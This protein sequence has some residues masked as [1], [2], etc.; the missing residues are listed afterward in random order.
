MVSTFHGIETAKRSLFAQMAGMNTTGHNIANASTAGYSRQVVG[1]VASRPLSMP[2]MQNSVAPGQLGTGVEVNYIKRVRDQF[3]DQQYWNANR[4]LG[5]WEVQAE[6]L[7]KLETIFNEPS[8]S[9]L[10]TVIDNFWKSWSEFS[11]DPE[12]VTSRKIVRENALA[13]ADAFNETSKKITD[14]QLDLTQGINVNAQHINTLTTQVAQLNYEI[15]R[16]EGFRDNANDLRDQRDLII[17]ELSRIAN[18]TVVDE[19]AGYRV[20]VGGL[21]LVAGNV[22]VPVNAAQLE[23]AY[24]ASTLNSGELFGVIKS[25]DSIVNDYLDQ[26]N[27]LANTIANGDVDISIPAG[28]VLPEGTVL[29]GVIYSGAT[30]T[31]TADTIVTV[32]GLNGLHKLGYLFTSPAQAAGE[33]FTSKDTGPITAASFSVDSSIVQD[34]N[35]IASSLRV[36]MNVS[37]DEVVKGNNTLALLMSQLRERSFT[38]NPIASNNGMQTGTLDDYYRAVMGQMGV[39]SREALRQQKNNQLLVDQVDSRRQ[40]VSA[41]SLDEEMS[42]LIKL[43][44]SYGA[45]SRL[46]TTLDQ[47]LDKIINSMGV[48][49]R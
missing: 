4:S 46:M 29:N 2:G 24:S 28:S 48:V 25:R 11:K 45:A 9:G 33:F 5:E 44:H 14:M 47:N 22:P 17:D 39:E 3:L 43:Q 13:M 1:L 42:N 12:N 30:R 26:L 49:G 41:V 23:T 16:I 31:L 7:S 36:N 38:F 18:V 19:E 21:E 40:S 10:T 37:G 34:P 8:D 27:E 20:T 15:N 32:Q 6:T 35:K